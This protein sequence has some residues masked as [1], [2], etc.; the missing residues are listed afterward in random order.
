M[1]MDGTPAVVDAATPAGWGYLCKKHFAQMG[2]KL[3]RGRGQVLLERGQH[4]NTSD[5]QMFETWIDRF[6]RLAEVVGV[7][8]RDNPIDDQLSEV[9]WCLGYQGDAL[10]GW[11]VELAHAHTE[12]DPVGLA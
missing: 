6:E 4:R 1:C 11:L 5:R 12:M 7:M 3:G 9:G 2:C 8:T 10:P